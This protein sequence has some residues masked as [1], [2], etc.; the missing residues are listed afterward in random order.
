MKI[1]TLLFCLLLTRCSAALAQNTN[2]DFE[3][4]PLKWQP[5]AKTITLT[6]A[7]GVGA[8]AKSKASLHV[9]GQIQGGY[10]YAISDQQPMQAGQLYRLA[11]WVR[12]DKVGPTTPMPFLKCEFVSSDPKFGGGRVSTDVYDRAKMGRWQQLVSEF[13]APA[14]TQHCWLALETGTN[15]PVEIDAYLDEVSLEPIAR[16]TALDKYRLNP[17][18]AAL[19][20]MRGVHPRLYLNQARISGLRAAIKTTHAALWQEVRAQADKLVQA[21]PPPYR[22]RDSYSDEEQLYQRDVGNAMPALALAH[23]LSGEQKYLDSARA[24]ALMSCSYP[25]WG[26]GRTDGMDLATGHQLFG[27]SIVYDWCYNGL[28]EPTR[29]TIRE[30]LV[31]RTSAMFEAAANGNIWWHNSYLQNHLWVNICGMAASGL[32]LYDEVEEATLWIGLPLDKFRRT[33]DALGSDG[34]SHEGVAYWGYGVEYMLKF[35][36]LSRE[37]LGVNLYD[38]EW[39]R[40]TAAYRQYLALPRGAW[41]PQNNIVDIAD[42]PR[43]N[44]YGPDYSLRALAHEYRDGHAQWLA[45]QI[46]DVNADDPAARWLNLIWFDPAIMAKAPTDLPTMRHFN[47]MD[48]VS[49]RSGWSGQESLL[50]FKCGPFIGH[51]AMQN[52]SYDPGGGHVHPDANHF[53]LFGAGEWLLRDDG[54]RTKWTGQHNTLL[55]NGRGQLGE[56]KQWFDGNAALTVKSRPRVL[57]TKST[58]L[59]DTMTGDATPAYPRELGLKSYQRHLL[60]L[61]PDVLIVL[62]DISSERAQPLELRFHPE[63][64]QMERNGAAFLLRGKQSTLRLQPLTIEGATITAED[65]APPGR[66]GQKAYN[67]FTVRLTTQQ[68]QWRNAVALSW[69]SINSKPVPVTLQQNGDTWT[70]TAGGRSVI[71]N[72]ATGEARAGR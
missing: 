65:V 71:F 19:Q 51:H 21:G 36:H 12:V 23:V 18:P 8:A 59:L 7:E 30:T 48:I 50:V 56:G 66:E 63:S 3:N 32:A 53:A 41:T 55:I 27:L 22:E 72:W 11:A 43:S 4:G 16:L 20:K 34:A 15:T 14:G 40:H 38:R 10:N 70:F 5:R 1:T 45:Q 64:T 29:R 68:P 9:Q 57:R 42:S 67:M 37:L 6:R 60:F 39:W 61:K 2:W 13:K 28:G 25:T 26:L 33:M 62:D 44:W 47:D 24:W 46:D 52:F 49:S 69:S 58:P 35:M 31:K 17:L 54:Y